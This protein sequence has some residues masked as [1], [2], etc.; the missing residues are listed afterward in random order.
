MTD[1]AVA[2]EHAPA[3]TSGRSSM[4]G[5]RTRTNINR[6]TKATSSSKRTRR[7]RAESDGRQN[8]SAA[9]GTT[10]I[11]SGRRRPAS[12]SGRSESASS[13][14][15]PCDRE[16]RLQGESGREQE[17]GVFI[18]VTETMHSRMRKVS[19]LSMDDPADRPRRQKPRQTKTRQDANCMGED[20]DGN[21]SRER[22]YDKKPERTTAKEPI[23]TPSITNAN[24]ASGKEESN[25]PINKPT[26]TNHPTTP[27]SPNLPRCMSTDFVFPKAILSE[28]SAHRH[29][30]CSLNENQCL[31][32]V[33]SQHLSRNH[34]REIVNP[35]APMQSG[36]EEGSMSTHNSL[37][38]TRHITRSGMEV[39]GVIVTSSRQRQLMR[40]VSA[41]GLEDPVHGNNCDQLNPLHASNI[42]P[43]MNFADVPEDMRDMLSFAS[44]RTDV[45]AMDDFIEESP[46]FRSL[47]SKVTAPLS[48]STD[49]S[50]DEV[51]TISQLPFQGLG[52]RQTPTKEKSTESFTL[53]APTG[54]SSKPPSHPK[55]NGR[56]LR[57]IQC[58]SPKPS[59]AKTCG[60]AIETSVLASPS[61][62][63]YNP[64]VGSFNTSKSTKRSS[65][66]ISNSRASVPLLLD[67]TLAA[68]ADAS[69]QNSMN[70]LNVSGGKLHVNSPS[71]PAWNN[72][73]NST[74][75]KDAGNS[76]KED[77]K[78]IRRVPRREWSA[79]YVPPGPPKSDSTLLNDSE[80]TTV[81][82]QS[83]GDAPH[84]VLPSVDA[85]FPDFSGD[86][87]DEHRDQDKSVSSPSF[88]RKWK[89]MDLRIGIRT[90]KFV[91]GARGPSPVVRKGKTPRQVPQLH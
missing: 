55:Q 42:F 1:H 61:G 15:H 32:E 48:S 37:N 35:G 44:D 60:D 62:S 74:S 66:R 27:P 18:L 50:T 91:P 72:S 8:T 70:R 40:Q 13:D 14:D 90:G 29:R 2:T 68:Q 19:I 47:E 82:V 80:P 4:S 26:E 3:T 46:P 43:D 12:S 56:T 77:R 71:T 79:S 39:K 52:P 85:I 64:P 57:T 76:S 59:S 36:T 83:T 87:G 16:E 67:E 78:G 86:D 63:D 10:N 11:G 49:S 5:T 25:M 33:E 24:E 17:D 45:V 20:Y 6:G 21:K 38:E 22:T 81:T 34:N 41:L 69:I 7:P 58:P 73:F 53:N 88:Q 54:S 28:E 89:S 84:R 30:I 51:Y 31:V 23:E 65:Q 9:S 75:S